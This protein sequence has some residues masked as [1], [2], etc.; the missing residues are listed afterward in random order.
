MKNLPKSDVSLKFLPNFKPEPAITVSFPSAYIYR[1]RHVEGATV[2]D[3]FSIFVTQP[4]ITEVEALQQKMD[5]IQ[6]HEMHGK[7]FVLDVGGYE[8]TVDLEDSFKVNET[9]VEMIFKVRSERPYRPWYSSWLNSSLFDSLR[10][11]K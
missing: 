6:T 9:C 3:R 1:Y 2:F 11:R 5:M 4:L 7:Y 8:S 10:S